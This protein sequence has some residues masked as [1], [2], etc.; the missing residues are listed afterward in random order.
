MK[1]ICHKSDG[2]WVA[3][4]QIG[5]P[6]R[7]IFVTL[8]KKT[9]KWLK[10]AWDQIIINPEVIEHSQKTVVEIEWCLSLPGLE[11]KVERYDWVKIKFQD[12][13]GKHMEKKYKWFDARIIQHEID[14]INGILYIDKAINIRHQ[15]V[16]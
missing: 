13:Y 14:H 4:P 16:L 8:W 6:L 3:A 12:I 11:W 15:N 9:P 7:V 2:V 1:L 5:V 10:M